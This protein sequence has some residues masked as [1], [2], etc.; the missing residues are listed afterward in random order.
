MG[1]QCSSPTSPKEGDMGHPEFIASH[2]NQK[3]A[4]RM[5][6]PLLE[7]LAEFQSRE[8]EEGE[9]EGHDPEPNDDLGLAPAELFEVVM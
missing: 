1:H 5:G 7:H 2:R 8:G 9:N 6:H 4:V 3:T